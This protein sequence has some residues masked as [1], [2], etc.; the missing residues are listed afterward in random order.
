MQILNDLKHML[1]KVKKDIL[2][3]PIRHIERE[4]SAWV[5]WGFM[6]I[7]SLGTYLLRVFSQLDLTTQLSHILN[8]KLMRLLKSWLL[9]GVKLLTFMVQVV[10]MLIYWLLLLMLVVGLYVVG[11]L[12]V[13]S[14]IE[15]IA[16]LIKLYQGVIK[17]RTNT[18]KSFLSR[19]D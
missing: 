9:K 4:V 8:Q 19:K 17:L 5:Q 10:E 2:N 11:L 14:L 13:L 3:L 18:W 7:Y 12:L 1:E 15:L 16:I 6:H